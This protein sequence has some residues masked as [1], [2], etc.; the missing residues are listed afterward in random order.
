MWESFNIIKA[1]IVIT[2]PITTKAI[3]TILLTPRYDPINTS[4]FLVSRAVVAPSVASRDFSNELIVACESLSSRALFIVSNKLPTIG[5]SLTGDLGVSGSVGSVWSGEAVSG[6]SG[7]L[8]VSSI[9]GVSPF[10]PLPSPLSSPAAPPGR[11]GSFGVAEGFGNGFT[12]SGSVHRL[13][14]KKLR[15][16][17]RSPP[18]PLPP[19]DVVGLG[20][21]EVDGDLDGRGD[22]LTEV[23]RL[24]VKV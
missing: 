9:G 2:I 15:I 13:K 12:T 7:S 21:G 5:T 8:G 17:Q 11:L 18:V 10:S 22:G 1:T 23:V 16:P 6:L 3:P 4:G 24:V 20:D 19:P 14:E